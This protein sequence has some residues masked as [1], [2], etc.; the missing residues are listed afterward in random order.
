MKNAVLNK[1]AILCFFSIAFLPVAQAENEDIVL[2]KGPDASVTRQDFEAF[3]DKLPPSNRTDF[4]LD[5][6]KINSVLQDIYVK[7]VL[8]NEA[9]LRSLDKNPLVAKKIEQLADNELALRRIDQVLKAAPLPEFEARAQEKYKINMGQY[10]VPQK[11][12]VWHFLVD[13]KKQDKDF[14]LKRANEIYAKVIAGTEDLGEL[15]KSGSDDPSAKYNGGKLVSMEV[16]KLVK[17][18]AAATLA[19]EPGQVSKPVETEFGYHIIKLIE[20]KEAY[21]QPFEMV[22]DSII[23]GLKNSYLDEMKFNYMN[24][25]KENKDINVNA[26][27]ILEIR[28]KIID[29]EESSQKTGDK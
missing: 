29:Q 15:A 23:N 4:L 2:I 21:V 24:G 14:A 17:P 25:I 3:V 28:P 27:A 11:V 1:I 13:A 19:L 7:R 26:E 22:K 12:S 16:G 10:K 5:Q 18:F 9:R 8:A 20:K 6:K